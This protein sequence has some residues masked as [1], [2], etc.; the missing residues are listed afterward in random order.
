MLI[1]EKTCVIPINYNVID[2]IHHIL[3]KVATQQNQRPPNY[4]PISVSSQMGGGGGS[5]GIL[6]ELDTKIFQYTGIRPSIL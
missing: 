4:A 2:S 6:G 1:H 5:A 3:S